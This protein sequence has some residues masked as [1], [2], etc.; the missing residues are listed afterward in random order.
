MRRKAR[1][2]GYAESSL[3][4]SDRAH[5]HHRSKIP[6]NTFPKYVS[7]ILMAT[8]LGYWKVSHNIV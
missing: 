4:I 2:V 3:T 1:D 6:E 8:T 7:G 5:V